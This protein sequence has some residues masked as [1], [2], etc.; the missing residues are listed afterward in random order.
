[1]VGD[2]VARLPGI[3]MLKVR[4]FGESAWALTCTLQFKYDYMN[5]YPFHIGLCLWDVSSC[6]PIG[7]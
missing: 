6:E 3:D 7:S 5:S 4:V 2:E 1:M